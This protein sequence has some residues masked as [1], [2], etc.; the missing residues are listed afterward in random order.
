MSEI[1]LPNLEDGF[2]FIEH[3][4][5]KI[6][7]VIAIFNDKN[8]IMYI[9]DSKPDTIGQLIDQIKE[10]KIKLINKIQLP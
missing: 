9:G 2:Y 4:E 3:T 5:T 8:Q 7:S 6:I 10:G 1:I